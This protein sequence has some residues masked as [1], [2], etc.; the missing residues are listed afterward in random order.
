MLKCS[1]PPPIMPLHHICK[2]IPLLSPVLF[3]YFT[4][5]VTGRHRGPK[6]K[7][8]VGYRV[9][10][11]QWASYFLSSSVAL[12]AFSALCMYSRASSSAP[13]L[14]LCRISFVWQHPLLRQPMEKNRVLNQSLS[15][16]AY[17]MPQE[18]K[19]SLPNI[20]CICFWLLISV[21]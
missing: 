10:S 9:P 8:P 21:H 14:P 7:L 3:I 16:P 4:S 2:A 17:L 13:M 12:L 5:N 20:F 19:L 6:R 11:L 15:H 18:P 1:Q